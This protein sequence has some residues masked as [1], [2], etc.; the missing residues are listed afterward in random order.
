M[1]IDLDIIREAL[2]VLAKGLQMTLLV[3][4]IG[5]PAGILA[6]A[7]FAYLG[8]GRN[9]LLRLAAKTYVE[10]VRNIPFLI[11]IY[12]SY[13]GLPKLGLRL[14]AF[15]VALAATAF[16]T[17]G[18]FCEVMRAA[19]HS[20]PKGQIQAS[21]SLGMSPWTTQIHIVLPQLLPF[22]IPPT[23]SLVI[24]MFKDTAIFS[25][26]ALSELTYQ[27][28]LLTSESFAYVEILGTAALIYWLCSL[29]L[30]SAGQL[31]ERRA[32][33]WVR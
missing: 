3:S 20:V 1:P 19:L 26:V 7:L 23:T 24:M 10:L 25:V 22:L 8:E 16:Y 15:Q 27:S 33:R 9:R 11:V 6:G 14:S 30:D 31:L 28:N 5:I 32:T 12:L 18:Y 13:F 17:G 29:V 2:P 21:R 4:A